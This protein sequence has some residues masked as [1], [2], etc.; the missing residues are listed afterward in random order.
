MT[1]PTFQPFSARHHRERKWIDGD[2]PVT[3]RNGL[4][5]VLSGAIEKYFLRD[6]IVVA[7]ELRRI[8]RATP[9]DYNNTTTQGEKQAKLDTEKYLDQLEWDR[10]YDFC[11]RLYGHL[12]QDISRWY[13]HD[14]VT[15][16]KAQAQSY[17]AEELQRLFDEEGLG[18][19]FQDGVVQR[20][21]KRH[22]ISQINKAEKALADQRLDAARRHFSKALR[23]FLDRKNIDHENTVKE[24]V[25]A[26]EAA[27]KELFPDAKV[28]TLGEFVGW[29]T[30]SDRNLFPKTI[31]NTFTGLYGFRNSGEGVAHGAASGGAATAELSEYILGI[32]ASQIIYLA[33]LTRSD[34]EPPF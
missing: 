8:A 34:E 27:A 13:D 15:F 21:G 2:F 7:K 33:D 23:Y 18:Y 29:A 28:K 24:A 11:E 31:G 12:A 22:T 9:V 6:W 30:S 1:T 10:V 5:H 32:S 16:T 25:C 3:A 17:I 14:E 19:D 26:V 20:R 4:L